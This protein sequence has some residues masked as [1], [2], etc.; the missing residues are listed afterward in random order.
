MEGQGKIEEQDKNV[1]N[2]YKMMSAIDCPD[3]GRKAGEWYAAVPPLCRCNTG[4]CPVDYFG[5]TL[6]DSLP[7][8]INVG[9]INV[10]VAGCKIELFDK[11]G[12]KAIID[13]GVPGWMSNMIKAYDG[14][15]Y[16]KL[17]EIARKA[18]RD[19]VIR[20]ILL[21]QGESNTGQST[22]PS[23]V[24]DI[25]YYMLNDLNL[26]PDSVPL[27]AGEVVN[28][29]QHGTCAAMNPIIDTL[30]QVIPNSYVVSSAG[31]PCNQMDHL[32]FVSEGYRT[33]GQRYA[34]K[35]LEFLRK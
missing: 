5:R 1:S 9:V 27:I 14:N 2:R 21:H 7:D 30:P 6:V 32:H 18:Q 11:Y 28:A 26:D 17:I 23:K 35:M 10:S 4:L 24:R 25:Y 33:F 19:G 20:G 12:Y 22:W 3:L 13:S 15:P 16:S 34:A 8:N 31:L 29:D